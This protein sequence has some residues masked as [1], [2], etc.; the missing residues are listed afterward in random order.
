M[1]NSLRVL[2]VEDSENDAILLLR[3][4]ERGG[5]RPTAERVHSSETMAAALEKQPW[6]VIICDYR[7]PN[8]GGLDALKLL[9]QKNLDIPCI[10]VSG[11][12]GEATAV[13]AMKAGA[14]D[15]VMKDNLVRLVPSI[16][17]ELRDAEARLEKRLAEGALRKNEALK[18]AILKSALDSIIAMDERG[19]IIDFNP[20][21]ER[22]F[23][24]PRERMTGKSL[25][26][27]VILPPVR[28]NYPGGVADYFAEGPISMLGKRTEVSAFRSDGSEFPAEMAIT[29]IGLEGPP[30][31]TGYIHDLSERRRAEAAQRLLAAIVESSEDAIIGQGLDGTILSWNSGATKTY[32]YETDEMIGRSMSL[33]VPK[34]RPTELP[35]IY[36]QIK[37][38]ERIARLET[39]RTRKD[40][41]VIDVSLT[42]SPIKDS[43]G[44][45]I[46]ASSIERDISE[47]KRVEVERL[48]LIQELTDALAKIKTLRGL[49]PICASCKKIRDDRGYWEKVELYISK[50][51]EAEFTHGICPDCLKRLY[52]EYTI[53]T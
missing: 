26:D 25:L 14:N 33:L 42:I 47:R 12:I 6:D 17:R 44:N 34:Y 20:A 16:G 30:L 4:L 52:P 36:E 32:G 40:G 5:Y 39:V 11:A 19:T 21:A 10:I 18:S 9:Q 22:M 51:T 43:A 45:V 41:S 28:G 49:L 31:F 46:G 1:N 53:K 48:N 50:H 7:M 13:A 38:G 8:F 35:Q 23:G 37:R 15:Y 27:L 2:I 29:R 3:E 24:S